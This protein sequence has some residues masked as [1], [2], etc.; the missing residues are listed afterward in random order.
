MT[1][2]KQTGVHT[3]P[4]F[5]VDVL[6]GVPRRN[7]GR[8]RRYSHVFAATDVPIAIS[9]LVSSQDSIITSDA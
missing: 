6:N 9:M 8:A 5:L 1:T 2:A 3:L 4:Y 7:L